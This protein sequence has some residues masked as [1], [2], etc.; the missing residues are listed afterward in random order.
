MLQ[1]VI[2]YVILGLFLFIW[3]SVGFWCRHDRVL[4]SFIGVEPSTMG[5]T[6]CGQHVVG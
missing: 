3:D 4:P 6:Y 1:Y 2:N 5:D